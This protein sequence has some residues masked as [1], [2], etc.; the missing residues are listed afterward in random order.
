MDKQNI[1]TPYSIKFKATF[2]V[3]KDKKYVL[4]LIYTCKN[5]L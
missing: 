2:L 1:D 4:K 3:F 5:L